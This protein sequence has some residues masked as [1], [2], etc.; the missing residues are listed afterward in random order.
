MPLCAAIDVN[1]ESLIQLVLVKPQ[2]KLSGNDAKSFSNTAPVVFSLPE[3]EASAFIVKARLTILPTLES[4][5][6]T[7]AS[8]T[9]GNKEIKEKNVFLDNLRLQ[10][11]QDFIND[12]N[13]IKI[14][15]TIAVRDPVK[16]I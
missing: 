9:K 11:L 10:K 4:N 8:I 5:S 3:N 6:H 14:K 12:T 1:A 16:I 15:R 2:N 7:K 13:N